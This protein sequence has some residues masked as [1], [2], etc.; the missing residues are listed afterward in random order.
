MGRYTQ[1]FNSMLGA[2][3]L[4]GLERVS[5]RVETLRDLMRA[6]PAPEHGADAAAS[7]PDEAIP[8]DA[9]AEQPE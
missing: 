1:A 2:Y 4:L 6:E 9:S 8:G 5:R 3:R 7:E